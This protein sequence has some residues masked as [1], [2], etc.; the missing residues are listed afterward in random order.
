MHKK[1]LLQRFFLSAVNESISK[2]G[3]IY[4]KTIYSLHFKC[5]TKVCYKIFR[6]PM[7]LKYKATL[8]SM[9]QLI[10]DCENYCQFLGFLFFN[11]YSFLSDQENPLGNQ[12]S[13]ADY[14]MQQLLQ[15]SPN[16]LTHELC[17]SVH[18]IQY[19]NQ[20][21]A[22]LSINRA[23]NC[24]TTCLLKHSDITNCN[25]HYLSALCTF[26]CRSLIAHLSR[27]RWQCSSHS[28]TLSCC[29]AH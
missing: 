26:S 22:Y 4:L 3:N 9:L 6:F 7:Q 12:T 15:I 5:S 27:P 8:K 10:S 2:V 14:V 25:A 21:T 1:S 24:P 18:T 16:L 17:S 13:Y 28:L 20:S 19:I 11:R 29:A 23:I